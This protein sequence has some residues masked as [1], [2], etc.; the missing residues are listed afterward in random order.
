MGSSARICTLLLSDIFNTAV[1][2]KFLQRWK[3][4]QLVMIPKS[5][6]LNVKRKKINSFLFYLLSSIFL[7]TTAI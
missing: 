3:K 6:K 5:G 1:E 4:A 7:S 2:G